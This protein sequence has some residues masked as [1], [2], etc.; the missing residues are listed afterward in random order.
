MTDY[1]DAPPDLPH[2]K[3]RLGRKFE[4][5]HHD[6]LYP[7]ELLLAQLSPARRTTPW[8][9]AP[10]LNQ[11]ATGTCVGH[12]WRGW[13]AGEPIS[14]LPTDGPDAFTIYRQAILLDNYPDNDKE[15]NLPND[16]LQS[17]SSVRA[18]AKAMQQNSLINSF[19]WARNAAQIGDYVTR[20]EGSPIVLGTNWYRNMFIPDPKTHV[21]HVEGPLDGG[22]CYVCDWYDETL[23]LFRCYT[24]WGQDFG[25]KDPETEIGGYFYLRP[26]DLN[27]LMRQRGE[28][29]CGTERVIVP[30]PVSTGEHTP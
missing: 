19:V 25:F 6:A 12:G 14:H 27:R 28:A 11:G 5:D 26:T 22:H 29:C 2:L 23:N 17:G 8:R 15:E 4:P 10:R 21:A 20:V 30:L 7:I 9:S 13:Y 1:A 18:G 3:Y 16:K 24:S